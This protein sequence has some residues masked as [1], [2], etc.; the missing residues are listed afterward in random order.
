MK[1]DPP[2]RSVNRG[3]RSC[4]LQSAAGFGLGRGSPVADLPGFVSAA[5][6]VED[7]VGDGSVAQGVEFHVVQPSAG[8]RAGGGIFLRQFGED[9]A[10]GDEVGA[11]R[12]SAQDRGDKA[13]DALFLGRGGQAGLVKLKQVAAGNVRV[14]K[15]AAEFFGR[16]GEGAVEEKFEKG[17]IVFEGFVG[18]GGILGKKSGVRFLV[19]D[20]QLVQGAAHAAG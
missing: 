15:M 10:G 14:E 13:M 9:C 19:G 2:M 5:G 20:V 4:C 18:Q 11:A 6:G 16:M 7:S 8:F 17:R 3:P 1:L 12:G